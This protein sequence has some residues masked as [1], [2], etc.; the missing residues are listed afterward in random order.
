MIRWSLLAALTVPACTSTAEDTT[1]AGTDADTDADGDV[2]SDA[3]GD[4]DSDTDTDTDADTDSDIETDTTI[5]G[6]RMV[7][8]SA[9]TF[10]MG[11]GAGDP[12]GD[13]EDHQVTLTHDFWI[14][15]TEVTR[16]QWESY[17][18][19]AGWVYE[20][21]AGYPCTT[22][23][24]VSDCPADTVSWYDVAKYANA[25]SAAEGMASCYLADGTDLAPTYL[26]DPHACPGYRLPTEAEW[27]Y[28]ARA[29]EDTTYAGSNTS[30][31]VAW[32]SENAYS[33]GMYGHEVATLAPN[34]W[35]LYDMS[36]NVWEWTND[37]YDAEHGGYTDGT[38]D[39]DPAG[40]VTGSGEGYEG[41]ARVRRGGD[42][43]YDAATAPLSRRSYSTADYDS[44][45]SL[46]NGRVAGPPRATSTSTA[47]AS[48]VNSG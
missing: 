6:S 13:Y 47:R 34:A 17:S 24:T 19:N 8:I 41:S 46:S 20:S 14:G 38:S 32:T 40:P 9:G 12:D 39:T 45:T 7:R 30:T 4:A 15:E 43:A 2:D 3:D 33:A 25:L 48:P 31:D 10:T 5:W 22:S 1:P 23:T 21:M 27:E 16:G 29:G 35:G 26:T 36:G 44:S 37:W 18:A 42:W 28:A 11:G